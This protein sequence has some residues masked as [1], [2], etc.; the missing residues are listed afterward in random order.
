MTAVDVTARWLPLRALTRPGLPLFCLPHAG[1][2]GSAYRTWLDRM[3]GVAVH[4]VQPPGRESRLREPAFERMGPLVEELA[5]V[6]LETVDGPYAVYGHSHGALVG[7]E[8]LRE[9][10]RRG[11]PAPVRLIVS[12]SAAPQCGVDDGPPVTG[13]TRPELI[14]MLR[15]LGGTPE[16]LLA[17]AGAVDMILP[18]IVGDFTVREAYEYVPEPVTDVPITILASTDDPRASLARQQRW[19][20]LTSAS[21]DLH[22]LVGGHFAVFE[23]AVSTHRIVSAAL[24]PWVA[25]PR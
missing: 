9:I 21:T 23:Q 20:E 16:W 13:M 8:L 24:R 17:D 25:G 4:P 15:R 12:G 14:A 3:P 10:R 1:A 7:F 19:Q 18:A 5:S 2:G 6:V 11:G 22:T